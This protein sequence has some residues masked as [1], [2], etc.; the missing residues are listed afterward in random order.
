MGELEG[1]EG[2]GRQASR[3]DKLGPAGDSLC[4]DLGRSEISRPS[5]DHGDASASGLPE[6]LL[7]RKRQAR[8]EAID[9]LVGEA[10]E[11]GQKA[12]RAFWRM[13]YDFELA[14]MTTNR[15]QLTEL[16]VEVPSSTSLAD[17]ALT[18]QLHAT[19]GMLGRLN[20]YLLHTNHLSDR[21]LYERLERDILD[22]EVRD[23]PPDGIAREFIDLCIPETGA[24]HRCNG[25]RSRGGRAQ[26]SRHA[27]R[28][29]LR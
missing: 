21:E 14:P 25:T 26:S 18:V 16:G 2:A 20:I 11:R 6:S 3:T 19:I 28:Q 24:R 9:R 4:P 7:A 1:P 15:K 23:I 17:D 22:E 12:D 8:N 5:G 27:A 10:K 29:C 13:V